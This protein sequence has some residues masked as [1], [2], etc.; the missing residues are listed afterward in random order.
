MPAADFHAL[1]IAGNQRTGNPIVL[2]VTEQPVGVEHAEGETNHSRNRRQGNPAL[3]EVETQ[4]QHF[5]A[6]E[7]AL[8]DHTSVRQR[9]GVGT[10]AGASQ[11]EAGNFATIRQ[12]GQIV[13]LLFV[14]AVLDQ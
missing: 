4:A 6:L 5:L 8:A 12:P 3:L 14:G 13:V 10:G 9:G 1:G 11:A 7:L 2:G